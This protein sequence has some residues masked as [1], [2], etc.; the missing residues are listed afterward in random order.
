MTSVFQPGIYDGKVLFITG[1]ELSWGCRN[2][3]RG[4]GTRAFW[5]LLT[6]GRTGIGYSIAEEM[7]R[8][9]AKACI[10]GRE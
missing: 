10:V 9:G 2:A 7:M 8:F 4:G 6:P 1:G 3:E 5:R